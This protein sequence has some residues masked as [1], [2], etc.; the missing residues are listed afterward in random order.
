V[1]QDAPALP[2]EVDDEAGEV[3]EQHLLGQR[4]A[5]LERCLD[6]GDVA[7][8][9]ADGPGPGSARSMTAST[10]S[11][12]TSQSSGRPLHHSPGSTSTGGWTSTGASAVA[13]IGG[14]GAPSRRTYADARLTAR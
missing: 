12:R 5:V 9:L 8:V 3:V 10:W 4:L 6:V 2:D 7:E 14:Q 1:H 11:R 13:V